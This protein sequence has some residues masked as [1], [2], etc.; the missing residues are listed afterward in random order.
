MDNA[1]YLLCFK[2]P[3][4]NERHQASHYLGHAED[5]DKRLEQHRRGQGSAFTRAAYRKGIPFRVAE[6]WRGSR[7]LERQLK[8]RHHHK[9]FC[10]FCTR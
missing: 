3:L 6:V 2:E 1:V 9:D 5:L 7:A 8:R 10:P 4:G